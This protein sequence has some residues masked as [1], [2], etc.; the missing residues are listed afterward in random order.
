MADQLEREAERIANEWKE[1]GEKKSDEFYRNM[2]MEKLNNR[3][4]R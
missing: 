2:E 3:M 1:Q 4:V